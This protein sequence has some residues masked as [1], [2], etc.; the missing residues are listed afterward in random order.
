[1]EESL[2][3]DKL[4]VRLRT[5]RAVDDPESCNLFLEGHAEV[6]S[7]IGVT[8]VTSSK[9]E[10]TRDP[11]VFVIV[12]ES[13]IGKKIFGGIRVHV[14]GGLEPLP[15]EQATGGMDP[16][17][18]DLVWRCAHEGT[19][20]ICGLWNSSEIAGY[21]IGTTFLIRAAVSIC[22]QI[23]IQTLFALCAP[24]TVKSV[25]C[26]GMELE[27]SIGNNGTFYYPKL[28]LVATT[29]LLKDIPTLNKAYEEDRSAIFK[30]REELSL[31]YIQSLKGKEISIHYETKIPNLDKWDLQGTINNAKN[32]FK[33]G[34]I[35]ENDINFF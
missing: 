5:F 26:V 23:G 7:S 16:G 8:K 22:N 29:M 3:R 10:W 4:E 14:A 12:V 2:K 27:S 17:I 13:L 33:Q 19:G 30:I 6:L 32:N 34:Q 11:A 1:M 31:I 20:E 28:D 25:I 21:G 24:Y 15:I 18:F 35:N 9:H